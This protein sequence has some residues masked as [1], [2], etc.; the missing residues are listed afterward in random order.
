MLT[1]DISL[2][3]RYSR[4]LG[5]AI[6]RQMRGCPGMRSYGK[7]RDMLG[8]LQTLLSTESVRVG[9]Q[10]R[11]LA[12][13]CPQAHCYIAYQVEVSRYSHTTMLILSTHEVETMRC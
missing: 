2:K 12:D 10:R 7:C 5:E 1:L 11:Q 4:N 8:G 6:P 3:E 13:R 9:E